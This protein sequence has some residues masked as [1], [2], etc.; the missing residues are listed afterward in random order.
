MLPSL[1]YIL[2][3]NELFFIFHIFL[4]VKLQAHV[5]RKCCLLCWDQLK[6]NLSFI[7]LTS[8]VKMVQ[9]FKF[10]HFYYKMIFDVFLG[11][12]NEFDL[13]SRRILCTRFKYEL[14]VLTAQLHPCW[15]E[16]L[17]RMSQ[18]SQNAHAAW[19]EKIKVKHMKSLS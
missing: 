17:D 7:G 14:V 19:A 4:L 18:H 3:N 2:M 13:N 15:C 11:K 10:E 8:S 12:M 5:I 16:T 9:S 6:Q 1:T